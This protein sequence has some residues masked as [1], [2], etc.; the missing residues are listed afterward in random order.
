MRTERARVLDSHTALDRAQANTD[1]G[2]GLAPAETFDE[3][4][5]Y[6]YAFLDGLN[7]N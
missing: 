2:S 6:I 5:V 3:A 7:S 4:F 1:P